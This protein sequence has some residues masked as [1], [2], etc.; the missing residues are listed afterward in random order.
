ML[1][2]QVSIREVMTMLQT[3]SNSIFSLEQKSDG[4]KDDLHKIELKVEKSI[5]EG[6]S[7]HTH[8]RETLEY[9]RGSLKKKVDGNTKDIRD[10]KSTIKTIKAIGSLLL[11]IG[12]I[13]GG[14]GAFIMIF[15]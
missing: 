11:A 2:E 6:Q 5:T 9:L 13:L 14:I 8:T 3:M 12:I 4:L 1:D 7:E 10:A 15:K